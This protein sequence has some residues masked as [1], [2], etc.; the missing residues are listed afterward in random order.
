MASKNTSSTPKTA[1]KTAKKKTSKDIPGFEFIRSCGGIT[2]YR[3]KKNGLRVLIK[4]DRFAPVATLM[5]TY[6]V[7]SVD[8]VTG[9]TGI[10]HMLEHMMFKESKGFRR[11]DKKDIN[12]LLDKKGA[13]LNAST[14]TDRTNYYET[15]A[16]AFLE[17]AIAL[18]ADRM[19]HAILDAKELASE[20]VV[21]RN[22]FEIGQNDP[23]RVLHMDIYATAFQAYPYHHDTIGWLSDINGYTVEKLQHFYDTY[24]YP[25][26]A[27]VSVVGDIDMIKTL[28]LIK[29]YFGVHAASPHDIPRVT[30]EEPLQEGQ[31]RTS[32]YR[33]GT[34]NMV[35]VSFKK[36]GALHKDI[37]ALITLGNILAD[38]NASLLHRALVDTGLASDIS[39]DAH[40]FHNESVFVVYVTVAPDVAHETIEKTVF[41]IIERIKTEGV[42]QKEVDRAKNRFAAS[43][44][45]ERTG[46]ASCSS[47]LCEAIAG[48]DWTLFIDIPKAVAK[49]TPGDIVRVAQTYLTERHSTIG[50]YHAEA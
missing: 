7:G 42:S 21:V 12:E 35:G 2:E 9:I 49:V 34:V 41:D 18:E 27:I 46:T 29:K 38:G 39:I 13:R 30:M 19:R 14:W 32:L 23:L 33:K 25:N 11:R 4:E 26:N 47:G 36:P 16:V 37:P 44:A 20:M 6:L 22:E 10:A 50:Y 31:R 1:P 5:V 45:F 3:L 48:G 8:E 24:Y 43:V 17:D 40:P 28:T 15:V